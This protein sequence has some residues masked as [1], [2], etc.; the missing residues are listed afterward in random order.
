MLH[1]HE[2][3]KRI[4]AE[5]DYDNLGSMAVMRKLG[6]RIEKNPYS[7]PPWLQVVGILDNLE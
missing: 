4:I 6:M 5:T 3:K 1:R 7:D 2:G